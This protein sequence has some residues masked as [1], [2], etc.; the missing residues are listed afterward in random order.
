MQSLVSTVNGRCAKV[1]VRVRSV[2]RPVFEWLGGATKTGKILALFRRVCAIQ[3]ADQRLISL[4]APEVG[5]GPLSIVLEQAPT[6]WAGLQPGAQVRVGRDLLQCENLEISLEGAR[7][8]DPRPDWED[9]RANASTLLRRLEHLAVRIP[10]HAP[11][12]GLLSLLWNHE[13]PGSS[14]LS[15]MHARAQKAAQTLRVG[16]DGDEAQVKAGA[17]QLAGL[18]TGLTPS[19]DDFLLG[20]ML[21]AWLAHPAPRHYCA[22]VSDAALARTTSLSAAYLRSAADGECS[23]PWHRLLE[24]LE[25]GSDEELVAAA[26]AVLAHGHTSGADALAGFFWMGL[27]IPEGKILLTARTAMHKSLAG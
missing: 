14:S 15:A 3:A 27:R 26:S 21:C 4:V 7:I 24:A 23:S 13:L 12:G 8:W 16:W 20:T 18:G 6:D 1:E 19:G 2:S 25:A 11:A 10:D 17:A 5:D 22:G 9:L